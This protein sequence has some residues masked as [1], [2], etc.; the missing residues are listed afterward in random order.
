MKPAKIKSMTCPFVLKFERNDADQ[1]CTKHSVQEALRNAIQPTLVRGSYPWD[2]LQPESYTER[3]VVVDG[4]TK[5]N[6]DDD[7]GA[8]NETPTVNQWVTTK[9]IEYVRIPRVWL[10]HIERQSKLVQIYSSIRSLIHERKQHSK[11]GHENFHDCCSIQVPLELET[12]DLVFTTNN[13]N[14]TTV[15]TNDKA[16]Q[17]QYQHDH[18]DDYTRTCSP[19]KLLLQGAILQVIEMDEEDVV[20]DVVVDGY[21]DEESLE[22]H[23]VTILR[24]QAPLCQESLLPQESSWVLID[25]DRCEF[26]EEQQA[27]KLMSGTVQS[28]EQTGISVY[29]YFG[30]CLLV[31]SIT[32]DEAKTAWNK[33]IKKIAFDCKNKA[34]SSNARN[35]DESGPVE[36][37]DPLTL[38][39]RRLKIKWA[40]GKFYPGTISNYDPRTGKHR[41]L[42]DD[43]DVKEY[44]LSMKTIEWMQD[45]D[46]GDKPC[47]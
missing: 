47:R 2:T 6:A 21:N 44:N 20:D 3:I 11:R 35:S 43:G 27:I 45:N 36:G 29:K 42:Y 17:Q 5:N 46:D 33:V 34:V 24:M 32:N 12:S 18:N 10:L 8:D 19:R 23:S 7:N 15:Q 30:A 1:D 14:P 13:S 25:D 26:V 4:Q 39:G 31:Y 28:I 9:R 16:Q 22:L 37:T 40:K 38:V 41:V